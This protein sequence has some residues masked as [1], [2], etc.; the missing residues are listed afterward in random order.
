VNDDHLERERAKELGYDALTPIDSAFER[1]DISQEEWHA[2]VM[3][4]I[5][6]AYLGA[7]T[8]QQGS[9]H[10][11]SPEAWRESRGLILEAIDRSGTFLDIGCA[12]GLL[13]ASITAWASERGLAIEPYGVEISGSLA[14]LARSRHPEWAERI[15][16]ANA[17]G[18]QPPM[19]FDHVRTGLEYVPP[20]R[21]EAYVSHLLQHVVAPGGRLIIGKNNEDR[22]RSAIADALRSW[23]R[24]DV[25]EV[26]R[27][28]A[29][30]DVEISVVWIQRP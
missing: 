20:S 11:G 6:P 17:D 1:G 25:H 10:S 28:H 24:A 30:P 16:T 18:W 5:E 3:A 23:G 15:W 7:T 27:P 12:N 9:G 13:M 29:H 14:S 21:R 26:R 2:R 8:E 22:G 19:R 4:V